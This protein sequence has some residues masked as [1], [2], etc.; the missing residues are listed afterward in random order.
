MA[1]KKPAPKKDAPKKGRI[2]KVIDQARE[3][4]TLLET[5]KEEG[6]ANAAMFL[7]M[8]GAMASGASKNLRV[9]HLRPHLRELVQSLGFATRSEV[10]KLEER[11]EEL[12]DRLASVEAAHSH[13][14][15]DDE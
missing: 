11:I 3:P 14:H 13:H 1:K 7:S 4:L 9:D 8:A 10:E 12:E 2:K 6:I 5:L 15:H